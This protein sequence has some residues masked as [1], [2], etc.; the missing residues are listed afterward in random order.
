[1][2]SA[3]GARRVGFLAQVNRR[4]GPRRVN[5]SFTK[6]TWLAPG[7][8]IHAGGDG[9]NVAWSFK[10]GA[11][12]RRLD[13]SSLNV[14]GASSC[15]SDPDPSDARGR[16]GGGVGMRPPVARVPRR[17]GVGRRAERYEAS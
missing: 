7:H 5:V 15:P 4:A 3:T 13:V 16:A 17:G 9:W 2:Q 6:D 14:V 8:G 10:E 11:Q 12:A 1:M